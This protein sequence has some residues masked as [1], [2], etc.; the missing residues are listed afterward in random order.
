MKEI[1]QVFA[2]KVGKNLPKKLFPPPW[3]GG[4][5]NL[6]HKMPYQKDSQGVKLALRANFTPTYNLIHG[7]SH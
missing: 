3:D 4:W 2:H 6:P 7:K 1:V 5:G